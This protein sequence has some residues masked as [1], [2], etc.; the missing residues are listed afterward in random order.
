MNISKLLLLL[1][2][3]TVLGTAGGSSSEQHSGSSTRSYNAQHKDDHGDDHGEGG[4]S[5]HDRRSSSRSSGKISNELQQL[6]DGNRRYLNAR[7]EHPHQLPER[8]LEVA[9]GQHPFAIV[10]TC[11]D[12]RVP[13]E[14][15]FDQGLGDIF[16]VR[17]AGNIVDDAIIGSIEYAAEH[18]GA[19][20]I[21]VM[22]HKRCGAVDAAVKGG[23]MPGHIGS[24]VRAI[25]PAV[26]KARKKPGDLLDNCVRMNVEMTVDKLQECKP[27]LSHLVEEG[28]L[29]VVG[30]YYD[31]DDGSVQFLK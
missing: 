22:G 15:L 9:K 25:S 29:E 26:V 2:A 12:S 30:A 10:L 23:E 31:L 4:H 17:V 8:R 21:V 28:K 1:I 18:L 16:V 6:M 19:P 7:M 3:A 20:L 14:V 13:P 5:D 27:I 24:L 11:A